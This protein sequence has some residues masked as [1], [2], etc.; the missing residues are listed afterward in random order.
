[1]GKLELTQAL[2]MTSVSLVI[3]CMLEACASHSQAPS[4][5][6]ASNHSAQGSQRQLQQLERRSE[7]Q[8]TRIR[9]L[10]GRVALM[11]AQAKQLEDTVLQSTAVP[12]ETVVI[13]SEPQPESEAFMPVSD[14]KEPRPLLRLYG[15][16]TEPPGVSQGTT[17][18]LSV[19]SPAEQYRQALMLL[20][21]R[22]FAQAL[23]GLT[24]FI[25]EHPTHPYADNA[26]YWRGVVY[27]IQRDYEHALADFQEMLRAYPNGNKRAEALLSVGYCYARMGH[28]KTAKNYFKAVQRHYPTS[29]AAKIAAR[30][31]AT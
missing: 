22:K 28:S 2:R 29:G 11:E 4:A 15:S 27:Y 17:S 24:A 19:H 25:A 20:T 13:R 1:M 7:G 31:G 26:L 10:E 14:P 21:S 5:T 9:E 23:Q 16:S 8:Q 30:E 3:L 6:T 12:K 18:G